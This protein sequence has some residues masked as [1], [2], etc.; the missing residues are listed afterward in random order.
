MTL[1]SF[2]QKT[3]SGGTL[4]HDSADQIRGVV[5]LSRVEVERRIISVE[6]THGPTL[7]AL[8]LDRLSRSEEGGV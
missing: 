6:I 4:I 5:S 1:M 3:A 2:V 8:Y 7:I